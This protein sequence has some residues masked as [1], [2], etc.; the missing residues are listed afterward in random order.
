[1]TYPCYSSINFNSPKKKHNQFGSQNV[2]FD[3]KI[4][5][6]FNQFKVPFGVN[7]K[8]NNNSINLQINDDSLV[9]YLDNLDEHIINISEQNNISWFNRN[10][11]KC[12]LNNIYKKSLKKN[13]KYLPLF[14]ANIH[15][16][17]SILNSKGEQINIDTIINHTIVDA[18]VECNGLYF[19]SK[20]YSLSWSIVSLTSYPSS[21]S[22]QTTLS[23]YSFIDES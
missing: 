16:D 23:G 12:E 20:S 6:N 4:S 22:H 19:N 5:L 3:K 7:S 2:Y 15:K 8:Y 14:Y 9:Q 10:I 1:M 21:T 13:D 11:S 18:I 17:C